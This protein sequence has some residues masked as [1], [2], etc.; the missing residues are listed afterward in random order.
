M[1][2]RSEAQEWK[3]GNAILPRGAFQESE[4][5]RR[6]PPEPFKARVRR[7]AAGERNDEA[8]AKK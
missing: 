1:A 7:T 2:I 8:E 5:L 3:T 6:M 4:V